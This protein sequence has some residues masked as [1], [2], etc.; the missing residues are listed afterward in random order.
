MDE[1]R[2]QMNSAKTEFILIGSRQQLVKCQTN[3][4][5]VNDETVQR[6]SCIKYLGALA[7]EIIIQTAYHKQI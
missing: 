2:L 5:L 4:I 7:D 6:S 3:N 1:N